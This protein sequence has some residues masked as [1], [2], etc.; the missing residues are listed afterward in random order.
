MV[1]PLHVLPLYQTLGAR[2]RHRV[3]PLGT[4]TSS[5]FC[6]ETDLDSLLEDE[7]AGLEALVE[8]LHHLGDQLVVLQLLPALHDPHDTRLGEGVRGEGG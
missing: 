6:S 1:G 7:R 8:L 4:R 3:P 2:L 5:C